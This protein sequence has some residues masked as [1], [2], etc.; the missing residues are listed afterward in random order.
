MTSTDI[1]PFQDYLNEN[2]KLNR[3]KDNA[4]IARIQKS[5]MNFDPLET[6]EREPLE[7]FVTKTK[8]KGKKRGRPRSI[9]L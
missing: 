2:H 9:Q 7:L 6:T 1:R 5:A 3:L 8:A 4:T